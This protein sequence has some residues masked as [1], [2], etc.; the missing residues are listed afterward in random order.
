[1]TDIGTGSYTIIAQTAAEMMGV[2]L[3]QVV[4]RLG[5]SAFPVS[6]RLGR[7][8]GR[9]QLDRRASTPPA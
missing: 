6:C 4:V 3:D 2:P 8:V 5:D 1:M 7:P 9:Q